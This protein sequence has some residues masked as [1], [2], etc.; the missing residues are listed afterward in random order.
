MIQK[1]QSVILKYFKVLGNRALCVLVTVL[2]TASKK[3][4]DIFNT[5]LKAKTFAIAPLPL[6]GK[7]LH[8]LIEIFYKLFITKV[9]E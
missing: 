6:K 1:L 4:I 2:S 8:K 9:T 5:Y 7:S 3:T